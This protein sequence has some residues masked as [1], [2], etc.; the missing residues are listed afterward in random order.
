M[1][2]PTLSRTL[3]PTLSPTPSPPTA[4]RSFAHCLRVGLG[5][6]ALAALACLG[7]ARP[8]AAAVTLN[9]SDISWAF[10][11]TT[12]SIRFHLHFTNPGA[13]PS[14]G[15]VGTFVPQ[16]YGAFLPDFGSPRGFDIPSMQPNG[17]FDVFFNYALAQLPLS[18]PTFGTQPVGTP[19]A[20]PT[21]WN[22]NVHITWNT[23][24]AQGQAFRH[25]GQ[26]L[27]CPG[28]PCTFIHIDTGCA[29]AAPWTL[30]GLC[31][32]FHASLFNDDR[33]TPAPNPVPPQWK[34]WLCITADAAVPVPTTCCPALRFDCAGQPGIVE[35]CATTCNCQT[36]KNPVPGTIDWQTTSDGGS[37]RFHVR[38]TNPDTQP[39]GPI[40]A[41][42]FSQD[43]GV[44]RPD[45]GTIG[46]FTV[47][48]IQSNSFFDVFLTV[49]LAQL[50]ASATKT[51]GPTP[52]SPCPPIVH[53]DG[54]VDLHWTGAAGGGTVNKHIAQML[55][56]P[57]SGASLIH[58]GQLECDST[59]ALPWTITGLCPGYHATL[60]QPDMVTPAPNPVPAGWTGFIKVTADA[61]VPVPDSCCF[62]VTFAC[63]GV[64]GVIDLCVYTCQCDPASGN[65][66]Q[67]GT[68]D[69]S[70]VPGTNNIRF[71]MRWNNP[72]SQAPSLP[73]SGDMMPQAFGVFLPDACHIGHFDVPTMGPNGFFDVF[74]DV[75][76]DSLPAEPA[77]FF[78]NGNPPVGGPCPPDSSWNGNVDVTWGGPGGS[79]T[80]NRHYGNILV[81]S[82]GGGS[83][84][85]VISG[86][87]LATGSTW[88]LS[89]ICLGWNV[90]LENEDHS[91]APAVLPAGWTGWLRL[92]APGLPTGASCCVVLTLQCGSQSAQIRVCGTVCAW[93]TAGVEQ[94]GNE[95][96]GF[97]IRMIA[98]NPTVG[99]TMVSFAMAREGAAHVEVFDAAGKRVRTIA[100]GLFTPGLHSVA[101]DGADSGGQHARPGAYFVRVVSGTQSSAH[102]VVLRR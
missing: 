97:G 25:M 72:S 74:L 38:W 41:Q 79:G 5:T 8:A 37:V 1:L 2:S 34:G 17:F 77:K 51:G 80:I 75:L 30:S 24:G 32:G 100:N 101:W 22:G 29:A 15:G 11:G 27:I 94:G 18:A 88:S 67:P 65:H 84:L 78:P 85:H 63:H 55:V 99:R 49:P 4:S 48:A 45:F 43:F 12:N 42:M 31:A 50:P 39:S 6:L 66:P 58:V 83:F 95:G 90:T 26:V 44:F 81:N 33:V 86:C 56:C 89:G 64:P 23:A 76:R 10:V 68:I 73:V 54:N 14:S 52:N 28:A 69:W 57:G 47:P 102:M 87:P 19:C 40:D 98:P 13:N 16:A 20:P 35:L 96:L 9:T 46:Q 91:P 61:V 82:A 93:A 36:P 59:S 70:K 62:Q 92:S 3:S 60:V 71:H 21:G 7:A 53:W